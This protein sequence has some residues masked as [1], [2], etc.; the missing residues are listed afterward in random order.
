MKSISVWNPFATL[1]VKGFKVFE[2]RSWPPP[3]SLIGQRIGIASTKTIRPE[4]RAYL[5][6]ENFQAYYDRLGLPGSIEEMSNGYMLGTVQ[7]DSF[8][9]MTEEFMED[10]SGEEQM[11]GHWAVGN[12]AWRVIKPK[13]FAHPIPV[14]GAQGIYDWKGIDDDQPQ[15]R[16]APL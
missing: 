8:E 4:Q 15:T 10:V 6:D 5:S 3:A 7:L 11:Y 14:R 9:I 16:K 12:Y 13:E 2:T 1:L